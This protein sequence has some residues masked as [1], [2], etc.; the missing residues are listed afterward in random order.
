MKLQI[1]W[2]LTDPVHTYNNVKLKEFECPFQFSFSVGTM[3][4]IYHVC[5]KCSLRNVHTC[6]PKISLIDKGENWWEIMFQSL[7]SPKAQ[8]IFF[9]EKN[10]FISVLVHEMR[11][12]IVQ[13][14]MRS[15][16]T[17]TDHWGEGDT[18]AVSVRENKSPKF[19]R[20]DPLS[21]P[22]PITLLMIPLSHRGN[23]VILREMV[24]PL[25]S[26]SHVLLKNHCWQLIDAIALQENELLCVGMVTNVSIRKCVHTY[27]FV[28]RNRM[29]GGQ[30]F[31]VKT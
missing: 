11:V 3:G 14:N 8:K 6:H 13:N 26:C 5:R 23:G 20:K 31:W 10:I 4:K 30:L 9:R 29:V 2:S 19:A 17:G 15:T 12:S 28:K 27:H 21:N 25:Y 18:P 7:H 22:S 1:Y 16:G 24:L